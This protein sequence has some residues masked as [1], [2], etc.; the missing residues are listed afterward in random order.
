MSLVKE[1]KELAELREQGILTDAEFTIQKQRVISRFSP[2]TSSQQPP[3]VHQDT[4]FER[5]FEGRSE[6]NGQR[7][8]FV[9]VGLIVVV[10]LVYVFRDI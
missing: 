6:I 9:T 2:E 1:L 10:C 8:F 7:I 3:A 4:S 5:D